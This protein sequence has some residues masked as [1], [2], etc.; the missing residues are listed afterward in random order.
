M[1][2]SHVKRGWAQCGTS[3]TWCW[4][5]H[6]LHTD[7]YVLLNWKI[8]LSA[9]HACQCS[10]ISCQYVILPIPNSISCQNQIKACSFF[11]Y[12][13]GILY[14]TVDAHRKGLFPFSALPSLPCQGK[15]F[16][17]SK[18]RAESFQG[19]FIANLPFAEGVSLSGQ[20]AEHS[21]LTPP[22]GH[23]HSEKLPWC[24]T[25]VG[26]WVMSRPGSRVGTPC[27]WTLNVFGS[28]L[29]L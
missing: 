7:F 29:W 27:A 2:S 24:F 20:K 12:F 22:H 9:F 19:I 21:K 11:V 14:S 28:L 3:P 18:P 23:C 16:Q 13:R 10:S 8:G 6:H 25:L 15:I 26:L 17:G 5:A 4:T 1:N